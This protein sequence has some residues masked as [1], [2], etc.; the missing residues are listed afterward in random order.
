MFR[1]N[2]HTV[3]LVR[4]EPATPRYPVEQSTTELLRSP[5]GNFSKSHF[6]ALDPSIH[7]VVSNNSLNIG[8]RV[9]PVMQMFL[10]S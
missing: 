4:L 9:P 10:S 5:F 6:V 7:E 1:S 3:P 2:A 8:Y